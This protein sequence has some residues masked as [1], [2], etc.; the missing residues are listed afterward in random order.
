[1]NTIA[2]HFL[3]T[4]AGALL[5]ISCSHDAA[6]LSQTEVLHIASQ[7]AATNGYRLAD[8]K[9]PEAHYQRFR[10]VGEF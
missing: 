10:K 1:M 3:P 6:H 5:A 4:I 7:A 2:R 8:F 9:A